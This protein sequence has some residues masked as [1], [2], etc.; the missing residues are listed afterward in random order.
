MSDLNIPCGIQLA[1]P[2]FYRP[3]EV[4]LLI[5]NQH[6]FSL[7]KTGSVTIADGMPE[8]RETHLGWVASG[9]V[10]A[11]SDAV[12]DCQH[13]HSVS[14]A[15]LDK[16]IRQFWE[17]EEVEVKGARSE[18]EEQCEDSFRKHHRRDKTGRY[19]VKLPLK[20]NFTQLSSNRSLA[21]RRFHFLEKRLNKDA[22]LRLQYSNFIR[23]YESLGHCREVFEIDDHPDMLK[24]YMPHHAVLRPHSTSTKLRVV[25][26]ASA[27]DSSGLSLND[28]LQVGPTVQSDLISILLRFRKHRFVLTADIQKMYRQV[29]V[30]PNQTSLQRIFWRES[31]AE[32]LRVLELSTVTYGTAAAPFL[33]TRSLVQLCD[34]EGDK[35][36]LGKHVVHDDCYVDDVL[37]GADSVEEAKE[38]RKQTQD[39]LALGGFPVHKWCTNYE[40]ILQ[41]VP[42]SERETLLHLDQLSAN[43][44][45][46]TLG[47]IWDPRKDEFLF[48]VNAVS[49]QVLPITKRSMFSNIAKL[50]DP[51]G[52]L[53][54]VVVL[55][56]KLIQ[57]A[58]IAGIKWDDPLDGILLESWLRFSNSLVDVKEIRIPRSISLPEHVVLE[59][60]GFSDASKMA[61]GAC[62]YVRSIQSNG[63]VA[64]KLLCS[65]LKIAP[66]KEMTIPRKELCAAVLLSR[67]VL[68]VLASLQVSFITVQLWTDSQIVLHWLKKS[69]S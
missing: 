9:E 1:D 21:L 32:K 18:Q 34:D 54:P 62:L 27:K 55:A 45:I 24:Y 49:D 43:E 19:I 26:D 14:L 65:K 17:V 46:K 50:F 56:K 7:L 53:S 13:V 4:D 37:S 10:T 36:P 64:V 41:D 67:L 57:D 42:P 29:R 61:F 59:L 20:D 66:V 60:H 40:P 3:S 5:G 22:D 63:S 35:Y 38:I 23:E 12:I 52:L 28:V 8:F 31:P 15:S 58:W 44:V 68:K 33:A 6:F 30:D 48:T 51:L 2:E 39:M 69:S 25:F 47:L 11:K 16:S